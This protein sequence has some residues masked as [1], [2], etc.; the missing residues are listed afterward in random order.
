MAARKKAKKSVRK[1]AKPA[2]KS[3]KKSGAK[4]GAKR[5][6]AKAMPSKNV[7]VGSKPFTKSQFISTLSEH[8]GISRKDAGNVLATVSK[9]IGA[10][11]GKGGPAIFS[12]PGL[13]KMK[14][15]KKPATKSRKGINPFT[16]EPT[17]FKAKPAS[18]KVKIL[19]LK[20]LKEMAA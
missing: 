2:K 19:P 18:R 6:V 7:S 8:T 1:S 11:L 5:A 16:G 17:I 3:A 4:K 15:V 10:H 20:G 12:W 9:V 14:I 13:F